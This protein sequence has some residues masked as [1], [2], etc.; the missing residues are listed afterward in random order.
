MRV[1]VGEDARQQ[2]RNLLV[3]VVGEVVSVQVEVQCGR[4]RRVQEVRGQEHPAGLGQE[5]QADGRLTLPFCPDGGDTAERSPRQRHDDKLPH[6]FHMPPKIVQNI[7]KTM[8]W[9]LNLDIC[10]IFFFTF[11]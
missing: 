6:K 7:I 9:G 3:V 11:F 1:H 5:L 8:V 4:G 2:G 10:Q